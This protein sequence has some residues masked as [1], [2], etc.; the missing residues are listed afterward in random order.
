MTQLII[1][2]GD[3]HPKIFD[4]APEGLPAMFRGEG[5]LSAPTRQR[6]LC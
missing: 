2:N 4:V 1:N 5:A 6:A 3:E